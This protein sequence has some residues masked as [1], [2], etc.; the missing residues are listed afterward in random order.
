[1][2]NR[3]TYQGLGALNLD[4]E[5]ASLASTLVTLTLDQQSKLLVFDGTTAASRIRLPAPEAGMSYNILFSTGAVSTATKVL[6]SG[7]YD[8][9]CGNST[10]KGAAINSTAERGQVLRF[11]GLN[12]FRWLGYRVGATTDVAITSTST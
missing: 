1:M 10:G 11:V 8:I 4:I 3:A 6:S 5:N 12:E 2:A 9:L 7:V